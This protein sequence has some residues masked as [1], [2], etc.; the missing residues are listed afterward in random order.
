[1]DENLELLVYLFCSSLIPNSGYFYQILDKGSA[2][3]L[4]R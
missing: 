3:F 2:H 1:M 4:G